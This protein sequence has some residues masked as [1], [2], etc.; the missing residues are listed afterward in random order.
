MKSSQK[1]MTVVPSKENLRPPS[2]QPQPGQ[3]SPGKVEFL[4][5]RVV[6][7]QKQI[8]DLNIKLD[9]SYLLREAIE[10]ENRD[11][12]NK[13]SRVEF[14]MQKLRQESELQLNLAKKSHQTHYSIVL[15]DLQLERA[16][17]SKA[18]TQL[19]EMKKFIRDNMEAGRSEIAKLNYRIESLQ[20]EKSS[21]DLQLKTTYNGDL[22]R[23]KKE[24]KEQI[25]RL[26]NE[27]K[28]L[29]LMNKDLQEQYN[30]QQY[31]LNENEQL[32]HSLRAMRIESNSVHRPV[33]Q[34]LN[35]EIMGS[36]VQQFQKPQGGGNMGFNQNIMNSLF[37]GFG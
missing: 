27:I 11:L 9:E 18:Q 30:R 14:E 22:Q 2:V 36:L 16:A 35:R 21:F 12:L 17:H 7:L 15:Q 13:I 24:Y 25:D 6:N 10:N 37:G 20:R 8:Q 26:T 33:N 19:A 1:K 34:Q 3:S 23:A 28:D 31:L 29:N 5:M 4:Q 32:K